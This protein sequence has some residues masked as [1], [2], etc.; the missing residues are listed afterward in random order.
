MVLDGIKQAD[1]LDKT[2][3]VP[4]RY[5]AINQALAEVQKGD[6][7]LITGMGHEVY[8]IID[9]RRIPWNDGEVVREILGQE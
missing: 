5:Q 2:T 6:V 1:G 4:D 3:E 9:G 8:R 7:V